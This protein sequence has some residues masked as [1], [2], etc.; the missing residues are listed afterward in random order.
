[1]TAIAKAAHEIARDEKSV[2][3]NRTYAACLKIGMAIA[4][5]RFKDA[6]RDFNRGAVNGFAC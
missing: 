6:T 1:M 2:Y 5:R 4:W 3:P